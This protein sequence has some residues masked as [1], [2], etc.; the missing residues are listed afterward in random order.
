MRW[1]MCRDGIL[2]L[3]SLITG[4]IFSLLLFVRNTFLDIGSFSIF[5]WKPWKCGGWKW[6]APVSHSSK[7]H[8][9]FVW[10]RKTDMGFKN[11]IDI[12]WTS[13]IEPSIFLLYVLVQIG[14]GLPWSA[15][16]LMLTREVVCYWYFG[17]YHRVCP[18]NK[19]MSIMLLPTCRGVLR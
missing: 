12:F 9:S 13:S 7:S 16:S 6:L 17:V 8:Y 18:M 19:W 1:S 3:K 11:P 4:R 14:Q 5:A 2:G 15:V 10:D